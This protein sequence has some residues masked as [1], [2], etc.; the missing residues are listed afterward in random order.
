[1]R[2]HEFLSFFLQYSKRR[3][4]LLVLSGM[5]SGL[6]SIGLLA[7]INY[8]L[9]KPEYSSFTIGLAFIALLTGKIVMTSLSQ[10]AMVRF[11]QD[12]IFDLCMT[13]CR[14]LTQAPFRLLEG[15]G[16]GPTL[17]IFTDDVMALAWAFQ[18]VPQLIINVAVLAGGAAYLAWLSLN[19]FV[20][21][22]AMMLVG[23][24]IYKYLHDRAFVAI[25]AARDCRST[26]LSHLRT[27]VDGLKELLMHRGRRDAFLADRI[28]A[29]I[30]E[31]R[32][33][34]VAATRQ[35]A[36]A[37]A[38]TQSIFYGVIGIVLIV[39]P[40]RLAAP[41]EVITGYVLALLY[42]MNPFWGIISTLPTFARGQVAMDK[43]QKFGVS[44]DSTIVTT[45][46][47]LDPPE[48][49]V[50]VVE[51]KNAQFGYTERQNGEDTFVLGPLD[52]TWKRGQVVFLVGGNGSGKSTFA[53][54]VCGLY[55][56]GGG[57]I[58]LQGH[59]LTS[60]NQD[61]FRQHFSVVFSDYHLFNELLGIQRQDLDQD[62]TEA[63]RLFQLNGKVE[64]KDGK[65]STTDLSQGQRRRLALVTALMEDRPFYI[66]DEWAADQDPQYK[67]IFYKS[68]LPG[69]RKLGKGVLVITHDDRYFDIGDCVIQLEEGK[70]RNSRASSVIAKGA[71]ELRS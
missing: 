7:L 13:L 59:A 24:V 69:L 35:Y 52:F 14:K 51:M 34:N 53:K 68:L 47:R 30:D 62:A 55:L 42:L 28:G 61:W 57:E 20:A 29:T 50:S 4:F 45:D 65:F 22:A 39:V 60:A 54:L 10:F 1:M 63:L 37:E 67:E 9:Q 5:L 3:H 27:L 31:L 44:L 46:Q 15:K 25:Y 11:T 32:R 26:L 40:M 21:V 43:I 48:D 12:A 41:R 33:Q 58:C 18:N 64:V 16:T 49:N 2:V 23:A 6:S 66:F 8:I 36:L 56:P 71:S 38:W 70:I 19:A 17:S